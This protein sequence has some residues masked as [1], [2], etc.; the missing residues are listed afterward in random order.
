MK[1]AADICDQDIAPVDLVVCELAIAQ[2]R[3]LDD[4]R[5][6]RLFRASLPTIGHSLAIASHSAA[7]KP[8]FALFLVRAN[9]LDVIM[10]A[11]GD[12][13]VG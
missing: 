4:R 9:A 11:S 10:A 13:H 5:K 8:G 12:G 7:L 3:R 2:R 6:G 1:G